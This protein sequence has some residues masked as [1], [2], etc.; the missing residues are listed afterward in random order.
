[1]KPILVLYAT[2]QGQACRI[3]E[4]VADT[5]RSRHLTT[6]IVDAAGIP[7]GFSL[8]KFSMAFLIASVHLGKHEP[9]MKAF[10]KSHLPELEGMRTAFVSV[11]LSQAGAEDPLSQS[12]KRLQAHADVKRTIGDFLAECDWHPSRVEAVAGALMYL[13]YN[14]ALRFVM[15]RVARAAGKSTDTSRNHEFTD[16]VRLDQ[17]VQDFATTEP[18]L[19]SV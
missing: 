4:H 14:F 1:M 11:S 5:L 9:E 13:K 12:E 19:S 16:W 8:S 3:A 7:D 18:S 6:E 2:R 15:K 10:I 17:V